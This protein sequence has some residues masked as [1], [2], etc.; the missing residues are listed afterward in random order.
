MNIEVNDKYNEVIQNREKTK[1][2][3]MLVA[4][5]IS[6]TPMILISALPIIVPTVIAWIKMDAIISLLEVAEILLPIYVV[7]IKILCCIIPLLFLIAL[8]SL[9]G[10]LLSYKDE[11]KVQMAFQSHD[12][13]N[14]MPVLMYKR[15]DKKKKII[16]REWCSPIPLK[17]WVACQDDIEHHFTE[18][19]VKEL[20]Y[21]SK[22]NSNRIIMCTAKGIK[23]Q[24]EKKPVYDY[25]LERELEKY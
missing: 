25:D 10:S 8:A 21:D 23:P 11:A 5:K 15:V 7:T 4:N 12:C 3:I 17:V 18:H 13:R 2:H 1:A 19:L 20:E 22:K 6:Q 24:G 16:I 9:I 14:G